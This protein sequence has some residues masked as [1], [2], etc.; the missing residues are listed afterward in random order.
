MYVTCEH[1]GLNLDRGEKCTCN[2]EARKQIHTKAP[3]LRGEEV[4]EIYNSIVERVNKRSSPIP[5]R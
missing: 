1:C 4:T 2:G 3:P 5:Q